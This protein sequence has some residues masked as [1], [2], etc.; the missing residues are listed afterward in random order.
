MREERRR[1]R[2]CESSSFSYL[3]RV[4][5]IRSCT[6]FHDSGKIV[7]IIVAELTERTQ[8]TASDADDNDV[9]QPSYGSEQGSEA[10]ESFEEQSSC[11]QLPPNS[12]LGF[13]AP[14]SSLPAASR[15]VISPLHFNYLTTF[16]CS[17]ISSLALENRTSFIHSSS[18]SQPIPPPLD[19]ALFISALCSLR[20]PSTYPVLES[21]LSA[22]IAFSHAPFH[23]PTSILHSVQA[24]II[25][26]IVRLLSRDQQQISYAEKDFH[27]LNKWTITLQTAYF[28]LPST[29]ISYEHWILKESIRRTILISVIL[30]SFYCFSKDGY[31]EL[32]PL[33]GSLPVSLNARPWELKKED[34][35]EN[36]YRKEQVS[37]YWDFVCGWSQRSIEEEGKR[38]CGFEKLLLCLEEDGRI[39]EAGWELI[40]NVNLARV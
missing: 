32:A 26:Q 38:K 35:E 4:Q 9:S 12:D 19:S 37:S 1:M 16:L 3:Q 2:L 31:T 10:L 11:S 39:G 17:T 27:R 14:I 20:A 18:L 23:S 25:F 8:V 30:R 21:R 36:E 13:L 22:L 7:L 28:T 29:S 6:V 24:L 33:L 5:R 34:V 15:V 40:H